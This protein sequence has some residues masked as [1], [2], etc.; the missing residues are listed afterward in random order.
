MEPIRE[1]KNFLVENFDMSKY[2]TS[3]AATLTV[4]VILA[5]ASG[6]TWLIKWLLGLAGV[7]IPYPWLV[8]IGVLAGI[9]LLWG[10]AFFANRIHLK[11]LSQ[12]IPEDSSP[13]PPTP[14]IASGSAA[15]TLNASGSVIYAGD[16]GEVSQME[17]VF[18]DFINPKSKIFLRVGQTF[19]PAIG[20]FG[21]LRRTT[22]LLLEYPSTGPPQ[23]DSDLESD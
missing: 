22:W 20:K 11:K 16:S 18:V 14:S 3:V 7:D 17:G 1:D 8:T 4:T 15:S 6:I 23:E 9:L 2:V 12:R 10:V 13:T 5:T 19:P 21:F